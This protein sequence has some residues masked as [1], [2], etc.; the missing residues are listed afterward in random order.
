MLTGI[1]A[2]RGGGRSSRR[3]GGGGGEPNPPL[4]RS[5]SPGRD[6]W[7]IGGGA[8]ERADD[9]GK[10]CSPLVGHKHRHRHRHRH[11][12][13]VYAG[14]RWEYQIWGYLFLTFSPF[15]DILFCFVFELIIFFE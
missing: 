9:E 12:R 2:M 11:R 14:T 1:D 7:G 10:F 3:S 5:P 4:L 15:F 13:T 8:G 6:G